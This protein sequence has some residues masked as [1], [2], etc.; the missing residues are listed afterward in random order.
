MPQSSKAKI[1][2]AVNEAKKQRDREKLNAV[3]REIEKTGRAI[4]HFLTDEEIRGTNTSFS[5]IQRKLKELDRLVHRLMVIRGNCRYTGPPG[6]NLRFGKF[7]AK[8]KQNASSPA[9]GQTMK[10]GSHKNNR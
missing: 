5:E 9:Q 1:G 7:A 3:A 2:A 8:A 10:A 4:L 6:Q